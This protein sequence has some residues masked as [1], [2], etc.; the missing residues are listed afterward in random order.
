MRRGEVYRLRLG[1]RQGH[2]QAG[3]RFGVIVQSDALMRLSTVLV[4]PTSTAARR[5][6]FR[7]EIEV[8]G[9]VTRVL[10]EQTGAIDMS[11]LGDH[12]GH[13]SVEE[14][15]G[16]DLALASVLDLQ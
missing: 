2:E 13:L 5:A 4:A 7:P 3:A 6:T 8:D 1:R 10:V 9:V 12:L 11:R 15:W 16:V 14:Q